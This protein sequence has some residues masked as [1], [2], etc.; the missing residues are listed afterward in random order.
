MQRGKKKKHQ[1]T[2]SSLSHKIAALEAQ[3]KCSLASRVAKDL[4]DTRALLLEELFKRAW[5]QQV[6]SQKLFYEQGNKPGRL[7][8]R[9]TQKCTLAS[10]VHCIVDRAGVA[11]SK[12]KEIAR[13]FQSFYSKL[14]DLQSHKHRLVNENKRANLIQEFLGTYSPQALSAEDWQAL[15]AQLSVEE[16]GKA[17]KATK[18][19]K[20]PEPDGFPVQYYKSFKEILAPGFLRAFNTLSHIS[21][22]SGNLLEAYISVIPKENKD[23]RDVTSYRPISLLNVDMK[24]FAKI[25]EG[26]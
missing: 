13:Q 18:P 2:I 5:K 23:P 6:L 10:T 15:E 24:L 20:S 4:A 25:L 9:L 3:H 19:G 8:A 11:H 22:S 1:A 7:L 16:W 14:Y 21:C 12:N 26:V 17:L